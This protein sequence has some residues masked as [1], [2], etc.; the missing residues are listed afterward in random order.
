VNCEDDDEVFGEMNNEEPK[1][2]NYT[3][4]EGVVYL[5]CYYCAAR[6]QLNDALGGLLDVVS[7]N[8]LPTHVRTESCIGRT[9]EPSVDSNYL[10][11]SEKKES[12]DKQDIMTMSGIVMVNRTLIKACI[13]LLC[14][15]R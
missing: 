8:T 10:P 2:Q 5:L 11:S 13:N 12:S 1:T 3:N 15:R 14:R 7:V 9:P 4:K 6:A